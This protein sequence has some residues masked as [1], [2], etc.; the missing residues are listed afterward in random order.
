MDSDE[1]DAWVEDATVPCILILEMG[2]LSVSTVWWVLGTECWSESVSVSVPADDEDVEDRD[3][4][5][6]DATSPR[7]LYPAM[8]LVSVFATH[9]EC[10]GFL[11]MV[12]VCCRTGR[13]EYVCI[14]CWSASCLAGLSMVRPV[15]NFKLGGALAFPRFVLQYSIH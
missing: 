9:W 2:M 8:F 14:K 11:S 10:K 6:K 5:L 13:N 1:V 3:S 15:Q 12:V 7:V 4:W